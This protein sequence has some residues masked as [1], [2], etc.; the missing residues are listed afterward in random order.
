MR[1]KIISLTALSVAVGLGLFAAGCKEERAE[2][3][4]HPSPAAWYGYNPSSVDGTHAAKPTNIA[5]KV[6]NAAAV[7]EPGTTR[8]TA[9]TGAIGGGPTDGTASKTEH[10]GHFTGK[11]TPDDGSKPVN[12]TGK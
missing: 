2:S 10:R 7:D 12:R 9:G 4:Y 5:P 1:S 11:A 6:D 3:A 8:A